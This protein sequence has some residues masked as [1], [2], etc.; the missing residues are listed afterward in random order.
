MIFVDFSKAF[1]AVGRTGLWQ[2]L[3]KYGCPEKFTTM[4]EA[5]HTGMM[6]N[7][8]VGGSLGISCSVTSGIKQSCVLAPT[9]FSIFLSAMIDEAFRDTGDGVYISPSRALTYSKSHTS[10]RKPKLLGY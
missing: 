7:I 8:S 10:E 9:L 2:L 4:I 6:A 3:R 5:L 1:D